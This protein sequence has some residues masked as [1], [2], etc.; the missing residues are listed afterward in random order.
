MR[1]LIFTLAITLATT[2]ISRAQD[3]F[4][5]TAAQVRIDS[6]LP[7]FSYTKDLGANYKD[8]VY[9]VR[10]DYP[11][12]VVMTEADIRR[13]LAITTDTM[14][15]MPR[16]DKHIGV[17][18]R[19]GQL[20]VAFVPIVFREGKFRKLVSFKLTVTA[21][22]AARR[23]AAAPGKAAGS[24]Q[25]TDTPSGRYAANSVL[26]SGRW[27][28]IR[29]S[30]SGI[31]SITDELIR[32]AGFTDAG[33][34]RVYGYGGNLVPESLTGEYL[35][36]TDDLRQVPVCTVNGRRL[37]W[38]DG[39]VSWSSDTERV[40]NPYSEYGYYFLT[41]SDEPAATITE[42]EFM[43]AH[44]P[45]LYDYN[46]LY[47]N[48]D[49]AWLSSGRNLYDKR[50]LA[51][52][53]PM[54]FKLTA[55]GQST[56][57]S[58]M[59]VMTAA[60]TGESQAE[61]SVNDSVVGK[62]SFRKQADYVTASAASGTYKVGNL[63]EVNKI[64]VKQLSGQTMHPDH[65]VLHTDLPQAA[66][67]LS[68]AKFPVPEY[69]Y[70]ITNQNHHADKT[71]D[72]VIIIPTSQ[73][74]RT[75]AER[76]KVLHE[77]HD[78]MTVS[79]V[80]ADELFNEFSS[81]TPDAS[82]FKRYMKMLYDREA[83]ID[84]A[85][86][87]LV[88]FGDGAW[89]NRMVL[90]GWS[91]FS[92]DDFLLCYESEN[93]F[94]HTTSYV[95]DDFFCLMDDEE[96]IEQ[97]SYGDNKVYLGKPDVAVGRFPVQTMQQ[98]TTMIDKIEAYML[99]TNAGAWQ[100]TIVM[101]G[102]DGDANTHMQDCES[103]A[104]LIEANFPKTD[105]RRIMW[106]SYQSEA[107]STG[108]RYPDVET[109]VRRYRTDGA[110]VMNYTG[111]GNAGMLSHEQVM[112]L[113]YFSEGISSRLPLWITA[114]CDVT[115]FDGL[116]T[117]IGDEALFNPNGGAVAFY[118]TPR[119]VFSSSNRAMNRWLMRHLLNTE[120]GRVPVGEAVRLAKNSLVT[121]SEST[122][123]SANKLQF[124]LLGDPA[125]KLAIPLMNTVIEQING[126]D[127]TGGQHVEL[128]AGMEVTVSGKVEDPDGT[129][130]TDFNGFLTATVNDVKQRIVCRLNPSSAAE[131]P[132]VF[133]QWGS[134]VFTGNDSV[135]GG[136]FAFKFIV[137]KDISYSDGNGRIQ[138]YACSN[139][140]KRT[141]SGVSEAITLN[142]TASMPND[143]VGPAIYCYLNSTA[144]TDGDNV[145]TTPYFVAEISDD[146]G[147]NAAGSGIGHDLQL[148]IDGQ[149]T[150]TYNLN[151]RFVF[152][153]GSYKTG[154][155]GFTIPELA[156]GR[157]K[158][159]FRAWDILN[160]RST[161][162]LTF[163]VVKGLQPNLYD[164]ECTKNPA[165][166][167]TSF[168]IIHD[169]IGVR[170][171]VV[172]DIF[173]MQGRQLWSHTESR[174]PTDNTINIDWDLTIDG[175]RRLGTG[176]YLYRTRISSE[177]SSQATKAKKLIVISNK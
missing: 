47:E 162:E 119:T 108:T 99:N 48:D 151:D 19:R 141:A 124:T 159:Q 176:V 65:I 82:A 165:V 101:M 46:T 25:D 163:N 79:I 49:Y 74:L 129:H 72:M 170:T 62:L 68:N 107:S 142:G 35:K 61:V 43:A 45:T 149:L 28:K 80:P 106:D 34:I 150:K 71:A 125:L 152:D 148:T 94:N 110:L 69:V 128:K 4:N 22:P 155:V 92:P 5:L 158:L 31:H 60:G 168:R 56:T 67:A 76:L 24:R 174:I 17:S 161:A 53:E 41:E 86:R 36:A 172:I 11:E 156:E 134:T 52:G 95:S 64:T 84:K 96:K 10:I 118:G 138:V 98:A 126:T 114:A 12:F 146:N 97:A 111:H 120:N 58:I 90:P 147:I 130:A 136:R 83:D 44:Y 13:Y 75:Q 87:Y 66:P 112:K 29:V 27:A 55:K 50:T 73:K 20:D 169:R 18:R 30:R 160:N 77:Q 39:P 63:K 143:S 32:Q 115:P 85:P 15:A 33:K 16:I 100:N 9:D 91:R 104:S 132:F 3:F 1:K 103:V 105:V 37:F 177:G 40:R 135:K 166:T 157:H 139:D 131:T 14:G 26:Q 140:R 121:A 171:D 38:A 7:S 123:H 116:D 8:S 175:G 57:G 117:N 122:D 78:K 2:A 21:K 153:F 89:D 51:I 93:S 6:L 54:D 88:M 137:P 81:G 154:S 70:R 59:V 113:D 144:F 164:V 133:T 173:D 102:D 42:E 127:V 109:L 145:N 23:Q 167:S